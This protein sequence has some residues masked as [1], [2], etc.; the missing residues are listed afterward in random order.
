MKIPL[1]STIVEKKLYVDGFLLS[2]I[3]P[4]VDE[5]HTPI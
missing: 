5:L 1:K 4:S 3:C 2:N